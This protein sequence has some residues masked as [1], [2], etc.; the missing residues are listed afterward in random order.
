MNIRKALTAAAAS[1]AMTVSGAAPAMAA[2]LAQGSAIA[3]PLDTSAIAWSASAD[4]A[5]GWRGNR[6]YRGYGRG[7]HHRDRVDAGDVLA[8]VLIIG[9]IAAIASAASNSNRD[10]RYNERDTRSRDYR[11]DNSRYSRNSRYNSATGTMDRAI[12]ICSS[13][14]ETQAGRDAR[15]D[16]IT[17][18]TRDG[19]GWRVEGDISNSTER[20]FL[21]GSTDG[22]VDF[23]QLGN[24]DLAL[25]GY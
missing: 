18:V 23:V 16:Q 11:N 24:G 13:A 5:N 20:S 6:G 17:S 19:T 15:V 14:A 3:A 1:A 12:S 10:R 4:S 21:C 22:R 2:P 9:G 7:Y 25:G 8:G